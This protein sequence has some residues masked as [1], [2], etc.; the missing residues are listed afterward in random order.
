MN[1]IIGIGPVQELKPIFPEILIIKS[2]RINILFRTKP[3]QKEISKIGFEL[4]L[5]ENQIQKIE[6]IEL[7]EN[8]WP[9]FDETD[10]FWYPK[11]DLNEIRSKRAQ[12]IL[13]QGE[14]LIKQDP[15]QA[16]QL[17]KLSGQISGTD[18]GALYKN[19]E[20]LRKNENESLVDIYERKT[21]I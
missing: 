16:I 9:V 5:T 4:L 8:L 17:I 20:K 11:S 10:V 15:I 19:L 3:E 2:D 7:K 21:K 18:I 6:P 12:E 1:I 13:K 14:S